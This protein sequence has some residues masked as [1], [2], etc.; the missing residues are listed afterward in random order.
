MA[1]VAGFAVAAA[2]VHGGQTQHHAAAAAAESAPLEEVPAT[3]GTAG[4]TAPPGIAAGSCYPGIVDTQ[5][6]R[7]FQD[8][9]RSPDGS[10]AKVAQSGNDA[11]GGLPA[12]MSVSDRYCLLQ[13]LE[14]A[15]P[16][17]EVMWRSL[18]RE[19]QYTVRAAVPFRDEQGRLCRDY[20]VA[21][22]TGQATETR[23]LSGCRDGDGEWQLF[24]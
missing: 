12:Q 7:I 14:F 24:R 13:V 22:T 8:A 2:I 20:A 4:G 3:A 5:S 23:R 15:P 21:M 17:Q 16:D 19:A 10:R 6:F 18:A 9:L 11:W 1:L